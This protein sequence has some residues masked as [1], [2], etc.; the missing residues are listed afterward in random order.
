MNDQPPAFG[1]AGADVPLVLDPGTHAR[2]R[3][4]AARLRT[5]RVGSAMF[6]VPSVV[7]AVAI[8]FLPVGVHRE[9]LAV[10]ATLGIVVGLVLPWLP[11][12][13]W[14]RRVQFVPVLLSL[15][16]FGPGIGY[17]GHALPYYLSMFTLSFV[18]VGLSQPP[19]SS[20]KLAPVAFLFGATSAI[21]LAE[22]MRILVP[23]FL[24]VGVGTVVGEVV[25]LQVAR[26]RT[27]R[28]TVDNLVA[29]I[30]GLTAADD[31]TD[32]ANRA[33]SAAAGLV[34]ADIVLVLLPEEGSPGRYRY[35]GGHGA[36]LA[37]DEVVVD[38]AHQPSGVTL[39]AQHRRPVFIR[40]ATSS[41]HV[42]KVNVERFGEA[43]ILYVP[44]MGEDGLAGVLTAIWRRHRSEVRG[45]TLRATMLLAAE[46]G[47]QVERLRRTAR[48]AHEAETDAL[49]GLP[50][51]RA[52]FREL[53]GLNDDDAVLFLD[54]DH[55]K[56]LND[57]YGHQEGDDELAAFAAT[58]AALTRGTDCS[59]RYGGE[60]FGVIV[61][62]DG[63]RGV[64]LLV[65]RLREGWAEQGRTTF[66]AGAAI[67]R[68]GAPAG[69]L[70]AADR[71]LYAAKDT[72]RDRLCW[73]EDCPALGDAVR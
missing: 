46:A 41:P 32:A 45:M 52:F 58:L 14:H 71:A 59:A 27:A 8:P 1:V 7:S 40:D 25:A 66:S 6:A 38:T 56:A 70:A 34:C 64:T 72:G 9:W 31:L 16:M 42:S 15:A 44:L 73:A 68:G 36:S 22:P 13:R 39:A 11:W 60:E 43:S 29:G 67:H 51:R 63:E 55:F 3:T 26:L 2:G 35:Y 62:G 4:V 49:T 33:A 53:E 37:I 18:F 5:F 57:R 20:L 54:L 24:T 12:R 69:T 28:H 65:D 47:K 17:F 10:V 19:R 61:R 50:N 30:T 21:G 48:L 23:V